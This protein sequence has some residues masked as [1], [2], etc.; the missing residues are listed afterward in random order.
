MKKRLMRFTVFA[1]LLSIAMSYAALAENFSSDNDFTLK[2]LR[3]LTNFTFDNKSKV[4][5]KYVKPVECYAMLY[6]AFDKPQEDEY[7]V[8]NAIEMVSE[9]AIVFTNDFEDADIIITY[10]I[11]YPNKGQFFFVDYPEWKFNIHDTQIVVTAYEFH[12]G[13][14]IGT[15]TV[16]NKYTRSNLNPEV[17]DYDYGDKQIYM[18]FPDLEK[19]KNFINFVKRIVKL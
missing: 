2:Q 15:V 7:R 9:D 18:T 19:D 5:K 13:L 3:A 4:V 11:T 10:S 6:H 12:T 16:A 1:L 14:K 8:I 17:N